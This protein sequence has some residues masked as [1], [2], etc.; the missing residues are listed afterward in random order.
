MNPRC[1]PFDITDLYSFLFL[2][3]CSCSRFAANLFAV[4]LRL[5]SLWGWQFAYN[6]AQVPGMRQE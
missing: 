3:S 6:R 1:L 5:A 2:F 4:C